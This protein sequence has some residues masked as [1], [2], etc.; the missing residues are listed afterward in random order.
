[1][2]QI[3]PGWGAR[4]SN[5]P[6]AVESARRL[7]G[8]YHRHKSHSESEPDKTLAICSCRALWKINRRIATVK[9][10]PHIISHEIWPLFSLNVCIPTKPPH[11]GRPDFSLSSKNKALSDKAARP[12]RPV[13][14]RFVG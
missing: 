9:A 7:R 4:F 8:N 13:W 5:T 12:P 6:F 11:S 2:A 14:L 10:N 3:S 1:M